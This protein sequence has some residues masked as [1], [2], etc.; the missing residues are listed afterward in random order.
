MQ[1]CLFRICSD[2]QESLIDALGMRSQVD[3]YISAYQVKEG[4]PYPYMIHQLM[5]KLDI[6][7][8]R[9][10]A[11]IGDSVRDIE[12]GKNAGCG[13]V[14]GVLSGADDAE[15]LWAAGADVVVSNMCDL[16]LPS[17]VQSNLTETSGVLSWI[18]DKRTRAA[19]E[20]I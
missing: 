12:E 15:T 3:G 7:D 11:K 5:E 1:T 13:L 20:A 17:A 2:I 9:R 10:V 6:E 14:I 19:E 16:P 8:V 4:R 18:A